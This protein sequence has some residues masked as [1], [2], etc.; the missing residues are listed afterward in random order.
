MIP[1]TFNSI[2]ACPRCKTTLA[3][4]KRRGRCQKCGFLY[5]KIAGIWHLLDITEPR[6]KIASVKYN[7]LH[8]KAFSAPDDGSYDILAHM[9]RGNRT[10]DIAC[11]DGF[12]ERLVPDVVGVEF[13]LAALRKAQKNGGRYLVLADA[14]ALPFK[15][16]AFDLSISAGSLEHFGSPQKAISEM[17]RVSKI[18]VFTIHR[19]FAFPLS[20]ELRLIMS[21]L[22]KIKDQPIEKPLRWKE[23]KSMLSKSGLRIVFQGFWN[24]PVNFGNVFRYLPAL[25]NIPSCF[26][27]ITIKK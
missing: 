21:A 16:N 13:S 23:I 1:S 25:T 26:F 12:I 20:R 15:D 11:G 10:V 5:Q 2:L 4:T 9:A 14:H 27:I 22:F 6:T 7:L 19:E 18:Q 8:Y 17:A 24:L 3:P